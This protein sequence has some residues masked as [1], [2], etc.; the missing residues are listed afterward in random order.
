MSH[1]LKNHLDYEGA[2]GSGQ[3]KKTNRGAQKSVDF[4]FYPQAIFVT[5]LTKGGV[6]VTPSQIFVNEA[7][8]N[9]LW[10]Q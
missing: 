3:L 7:S 1:C 10:Y 4:I 2:K 8:V 5:R 6:V 9:L